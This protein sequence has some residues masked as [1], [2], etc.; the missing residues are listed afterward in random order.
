MC[1]ERND[2]CPIDE[3][4]IAAMRAMRGEVA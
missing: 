4:R 1:V 3:H 2:A